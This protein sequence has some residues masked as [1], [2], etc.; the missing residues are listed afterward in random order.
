MRI[1]NAS[2]LKEL[3]FEEGTEM[4]SVSIG[5]CNNLVSVIIPE[6]VVCM[7][8]FDII[9]CYKLDDIKFPH[10]LKYSFVTLM[11][12]SLANFNMQNIYERILSTSYLADNLLVSPQN[13]SGV[14]PRF[15]IKA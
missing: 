5:Q 6:S 7:K 10:S 3:E 8:P 14:I 2:S 13:S 1:D 15:G 9:D 11:P 4:I 12:F